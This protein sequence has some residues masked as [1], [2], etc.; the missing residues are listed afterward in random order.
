MESFGSDTEENEAEGARN[1]DHVAAKRDV[2]RVAVRE[3]ALAAREPH[4]ANRV[5]PSRQLGFDFG[6]RIGANAL[7]GGELPTGAAAT[8]ANDL[9]LISD[10]KSIEGVVGE[11]VNP[12][13]V[14]GWRAG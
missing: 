12:V 2:N 9:N 7:V 6:F 1:R 4:G 8:N 10:L 5:V 11:N 14:S 13:L 3:G